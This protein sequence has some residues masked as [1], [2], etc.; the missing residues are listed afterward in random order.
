MAVIE[1]DINKIK[2][3]RH[4]PPKQEF[5]DKKPITNYLR[6]FLADEEQELL[7]KF[8]QL[9]EREQGIILGETDYYILKKFRP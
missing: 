3:Y 6:T 7:C 9:S 4:K 1:V 2:D 5:D 8:R